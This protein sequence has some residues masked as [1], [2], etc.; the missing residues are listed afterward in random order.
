MLE[1]KKQHGYSILDVVQS[2]YTLLKTHN[3][4]GKE[5]GQMLLSP[6]PKESKT[7]VLPILLSRP[8]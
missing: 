2:T 3:D 6:V 5:A 4:P 8:Q 1:L 7:A